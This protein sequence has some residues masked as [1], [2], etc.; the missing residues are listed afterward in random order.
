LISRMESEDKEVRQRVW[1]DLLIR[2]AILAAC[3]GVTGWAYTNGHASLGAVSA[4]ASGVFVGMS[5]VEAFRMIGPP[6]SQ[7]D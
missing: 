3:L 5:V 2:A 6:R 4:G 1:A 7:E